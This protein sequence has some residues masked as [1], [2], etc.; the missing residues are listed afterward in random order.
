MCPVITSSSLRETEKRS[1]LSQKAQETISSRKEQHGGGKKLRYGRYERGKVHTRS[2][3]GSVR[4][5][6]IALNP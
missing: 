1:E 6:F 2:C 5:H 3:S 4:I